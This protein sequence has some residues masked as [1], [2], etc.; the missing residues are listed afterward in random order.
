[1]SVLH[2]CVCTCSYVPVCVCVFVCVCLCLCL[3]LCAHSHKNLP[4]SHSLLSHFLCS[5]RSRLNTTLSQAQSRTLARLSGALDES[6]WKLRARGGGG[7]RRFS[8]REGRGQG[9]GGDG[10]SAGE[11][12]VTV[13]GAIDLTCKS[14][15]K[16]RVALK[17]LQVFFFYISGTARCIKCEILLLL[18]IS[19]LSKSVPK[20]TLTPESRDEEIRCTNSTECEFSF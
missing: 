11:R 13:G 4:L 1:M 18:C 2:H 17:V 9:D 20:T 3:C 15:K 10:C 8:R 7:V 6:P 5:L 16:G 19:F 12:A 14:N